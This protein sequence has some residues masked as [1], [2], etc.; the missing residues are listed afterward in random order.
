MGRGYQCKRY[1][2]QCRPLPHCQSKLFRGCVS[3]TYDSMNRPASVSGDTTPVSY[4]YDKAGNITQM[5]VGTQTPAVTSY[6]YDTA[7]NLIKQTDALGYSDTYTYDYAGNATTHTNRKGTVYENTYDIFGLTSTKA[8]GTGTS[9]EKLDYE[10]TPIGKVSS[11]TLSNQ[12]VNYYFLSKMSYTYDAFG[13]P[14]QKIDENG[15]NDSKYLI[16]YTFDNNSNTTGYVLKMRHWEETD[17]GDIETYETKAT[18]AYQ[19][20]SLQ[21]MQKKIGSLI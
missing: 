3:Y 15:D 2:G 18:A 1:S 5:T 9:Y 14:V 13:R 7:G 6:E 11:I 19:Y 12:Y 17:D 8:I 4:Q 10:Y 16:D 21:N 20:N